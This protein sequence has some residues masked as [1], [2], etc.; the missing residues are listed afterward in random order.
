MTIGQALV[1]GLVVVALVGG[2]TWLWLRAAAPPPKP[3]D[4][5]IERPPEDPPR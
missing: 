3:D 1:G 5:T 4:G 2:A